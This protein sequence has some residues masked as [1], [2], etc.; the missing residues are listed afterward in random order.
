MG[1]QQHGQ[2]ALFAKR[3]EQRNDLRLN[4]D[5]ERGGRLVCNQQVRIGGNRKCD[6]DT[7]AHSAGKLVRIGIYA[8]FRLAD[9]DLA[10]Q[11][12]R[13]LTRGLCIERQVAANGLD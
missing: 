10:Q 13:P 6:H 3:L 1:D 2:P 8:P 12:D 5:I 11:L 9:T 7:L 4:R